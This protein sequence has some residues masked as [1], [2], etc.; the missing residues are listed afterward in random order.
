MRVFAIDAGCTESGYVVVDL[1]NLTIVESGKIK[2]EDLLKAV[3]LLSASADI[4]A[5]EMIA[6][7]GMP[8]GKE[9]FD[10][11]IWIGRFVQVA[12]K[13]PTYIYRKEVKL[14]LCGSTRA[15]DTNVRRSLIDRYAKHD[16]KT[17]KGT[18]KYPDTF[19]GVTKDAWAAVAVAVTAYE[20]KVYG[21]HEGTT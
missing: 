7:Y 6:S 15:K 14:Y 8:V 13:N 12:E 21:L 3:P 5:L 17:G 11:C 10:T 4:F 19:H 2:N 9:V 1:P 18:K 20:R 16:Y